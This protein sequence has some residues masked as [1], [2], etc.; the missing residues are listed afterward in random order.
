MLEQFR[1]DGQAA[2]VTGAG[3]GIGAAIA[4]VLA[5]AGADVTITSRTPAELDEVA[6]AVRAHGREALVLPGDVNDLAF[7]G[8]LV[9]R[10]VAERGRLDVVVNN[11]GG[12]PTR[13]ALETSVDELESSF[14]FNVSVPLELSKLAVPRMLAG[15][16]P[17]TGVIVNIGSVAGKNANRGTL[18]HSLTKAALAQLTR[19]MASDF[20]P[21]VRVNAV[22]PGA[23]ETAALRRYLD[24]KAG[25]AREQMI[26]NTPMRRNGQP[27]DIAAAVLF[28]ASPASSWVT[29]KLL[30]VDG[31]VIGPVLA[32]PVADL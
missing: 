11:A 28:F 15:P 10:T 1:L 9:D 22:L 18:T 13:T 32:S 23:I 6:A 24:A 30:E 3:R 31:G 2:I 26:A 21:R 7:L 19:L 20:A 29:G 25:G 16:E 5:E 4:A 14:H 12:S 27:G 8:E 17:G